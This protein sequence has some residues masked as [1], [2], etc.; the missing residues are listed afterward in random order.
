M[1]QIGQVML[2][3]PSALAKTGLIA[4]IPL[5]IVYGLLSTWTIHNVTALYVA[6]KRAKVGLGVIRDSHFLTIQ[7]HIESIRRDLI[8]YTNDT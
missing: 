7:G 5:M 3:L 8:P 2:A 6:M 1:L 4:G